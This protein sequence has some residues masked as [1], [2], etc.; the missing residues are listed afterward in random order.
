[1]I[2]KMVGDIDLATA[3]SKG[4]ACARRGFELSAAIMRSATKNCG[5]GYRDVYGA[6]VFACKCCE[7]GDC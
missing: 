1:M 6:S 4:R 3:K 2:G 7:G 5:G